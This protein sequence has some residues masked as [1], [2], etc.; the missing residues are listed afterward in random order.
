MGAKAR[1]EF[2][3]AVYHVL[4]GKMHSR[5]T[6]YFPAQIHALTPISASRRVLEWQEEQTT[7]EK[8]EPHYILN[9]YFCSRPRC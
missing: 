9:A 8:N 2:A 6:P 1:I 3:G 4:D 5:P 7:Y